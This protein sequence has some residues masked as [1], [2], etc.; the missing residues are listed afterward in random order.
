MSL[1][2]EIKK[3]WKEEI[4]VRI[5]NEEKMKKIERGERILYNVMDIENGYV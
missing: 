2:K 4:V 1:N 5:M 3:R